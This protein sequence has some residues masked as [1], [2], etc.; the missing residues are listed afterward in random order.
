MSQN[1][2]KTTQDANGR[3]PIEDQLPQPVF[4]RTV[5]DGDTRHYWG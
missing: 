1:T 4:D 2:L 5:H 3:R